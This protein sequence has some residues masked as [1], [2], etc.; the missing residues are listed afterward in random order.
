MAKKNGRSAASQDYKPN[1]IEERPASV[2]TRHQFGHWE[3]DTIVSMK[4]KELLV[5]LLREKAG[6]SS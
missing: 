3:G 5:A 4:S 1:I 2:E 6:C